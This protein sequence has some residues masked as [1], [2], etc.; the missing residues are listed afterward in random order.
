MELTNESVIERSGLE[1]HVVNTTN[2]TFDFI[3]NNEDFGILTLKMKKVNITTIPLLIIFTID[4]SGSMNETDIKNTSKME[5]VIQTFKNILYYLSKQNAPIYIYV[6]T[7]NSDVSI[8]IDTTIVTLEN[9]QE[10]ITKVENIQAFNDTN[11]ELALQKT[12]EFVIDYSNKYPT[13]QICHLCMT[14][15]TPTSGN[16]DSEY[17]TKMVNNNFANIFIGFGEDHNIKLMQ[18]L[19]DNEKS[20]YQ[21][22][23]DMENT[24]LIYGET[25]HRYLFPCIRDAEIIV[26]N[27]LI[28]NWKTNVW[29]DRLYEHIIIGEI[30]KKYHIKKA[31]NAYVEINVYGTVNPD[32]PNS[33]LDTIDELPRLVTVNTGAIMETDLTTFM[34]RQKTQEMLYK[35]KMLNIQPYNKNKKTELKQEF[36]EFFNKMRI[37]MKNNNLLEDEFMKLLCDDLHVTYTTMDTKMGGMYSLARHTS[38]GS[39]QTYSATPKNNRRDVDI[40]NNADNDTKTDDENDIFGLNEIL[41]RYDAFGSPVQNK[42]LK[43][44]NI[45]KHAIFDDDA[46]IMSYLPSPNNISH[47]ATQSTIETMSEIDSN[48]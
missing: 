18:K 28:Y 7:F 41:K 37:Y 32:E 34:F 24:A 8:I 29:S 42:R 9:V 23:N 45:N 44:N 38:Q 16:S 3:E 26:E 33:L 22:V 35:T 4:N 1:F 25:M 12:N 14:D 30:E 47:Y 19:S 5:F 13:H 6:H 39:Q 21:F 31:L 15:G 40:D 48:K 11:I 36:L 17:L 46:E 27:G 43:K 2:E 10:L 20:D